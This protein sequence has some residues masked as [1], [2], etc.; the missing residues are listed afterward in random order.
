MFLQCLLH[1]TA[2][3]LKIQ[4]ADII[5]QIIGRSLQDR[6]VEGGGSGSVES[7][8]CQKGRDICKRIAVIVNANIEQG[9]KPEGEGTVFLLNNR[10]ITSAIPERIGIHFHIS[11]P[12]L[13]IA[14]G[15][16]QEAERSR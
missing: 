5:L 9:G 1:G 6:P 16:E 13:R 14:A 2:K 3:A 10:G 4:V 8:L 7:K 15:S 12:S 11:S